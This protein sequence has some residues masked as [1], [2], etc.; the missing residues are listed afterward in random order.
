MVTKTWL[1]VVLL[2]V[3]LTIGCRHHHLRAG[4]LNDVQTAEQHRDHAR[5]RSAN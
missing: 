4:T 5:L 2:G 3:S 1:V